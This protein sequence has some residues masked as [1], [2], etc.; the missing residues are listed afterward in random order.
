MRHRFYEILAYIFI[1]V[2]ISGCSAKEITLSISHIQPSLENTETS[3]VAGAASM[4]ITPPPGMPM[5]GYSKISTDAI[6]VRSKLMARAIYIN[7]GKSAPV[8]LVQCDLL[9]GSLALHHK[10][11]ELIA[12]QTDVDAGGLMSGAG[13][14]DFRFC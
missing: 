4:G 6:G 10:V 5:A 14:S 8:A 7:S 3:L 13:E 12:K 1:L 2:I 11:A 9:S